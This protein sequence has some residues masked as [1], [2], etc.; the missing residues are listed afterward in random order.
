[1]S[2]IDGG[3]VPRPGPAAGPTERSYYLF[4]LS[5][6]ARGLCL[7]VTNDLARCLVER[8]LG[9]RLA[10]TRLVYFEVLSDLRRALARKEQL[11]GWN[12]SR[13]WRLIVS[14]NPTWRDLSVGLA[15]P[16]T[17]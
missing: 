11:E 8:R 2:R 12:R 1:M 9:A 5:T 17:T 6:P 10:A 14:V 15:G 4:I 3:R 13:K 7:G 16:Q